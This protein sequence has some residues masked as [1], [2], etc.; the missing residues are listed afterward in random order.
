[1]G[2]SRRHPATDRL[3]AHT[4][5]NPGEEALLSIRPSLGALRQVPVLPSAKPVWRH[6][7]PDPRLR[8]LTMA[9]RKQ[10]PAQRELQLTFEF[11]FVES[12]VWGCGEE[13]RNSQVWQA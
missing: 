2:S 4:T 1:M 5:T 7:C 3:P 6:T 8:L 12:S 13:N 11:S 10:A 9:A